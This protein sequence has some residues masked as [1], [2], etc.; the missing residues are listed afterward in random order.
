[1]NLFSLLKPEWHPAAPK[2]L[3]SSA[4][5]VFRA[6]E[7]DQARVL[8]DIFGI[9][10]VGEMVNHPAL[11]WVWRTYETFKAG[12]LSGPPPES[13]GFIRPDWRQ[14]SC[15]EWL[16]SPLN[17]LESISDEDGQRLGHV[18]N[19]ATVRNMASDTSFEAARVLHR[20]VTGEPVS[21]A[22]AIPKPLTNYFE[23]ASN[24]YM[25]RQR[26]GA[27]LPPI[28][29]P[30]PQAPLPPPPQLGAPLSG[31]LDSPPHD[32]AT[33]M[34]EVG[35]GA[36]MA[37]LGE[38]R[39]VHSPLP[40]EFKASPSPDGIRAWSNPPAGEQTYNEAFHTVPKTRRK[41]YSEHGTYIPQGG[42]SRGWYENQG[43]AKTEKSN[44]YRYQE[45]IDQT[46]YRDVDVEH[47]IHV[48]LRG[49]ER[50]EL[51][52]QVRFSLDEHEV[53]QPALCLD[54]SL[55]GVRIRLS[56][57]FRQAQPIYLTFIHRDDIQGIVTPLI[58]VQATVAWCR[59]VDPTFKNPRYDLGLE[60][61]EMTID[62]KEKVSKLMMDR[63]DE[64]LAEAPPPPEN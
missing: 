13:E 50:K 41:D 26:E 62:I 24:S 51:R 29:P 22:D 37:P 45:V 49:A 48:N 23:G 55:T 15:G 54:L 6:I 33:G 4:P 46:G 18:L 27:G 3:L 34:E 58:H 42:G 64:L 36:G 53:P 7:D 35:D 38:D 1:M 39:P 28:P 59:E 60:F 10:T 43:V 2:E 9:T 8:E 31:H 16:S 14:R 21:P 32:P 40:G 61:S 11:D 5:T 56:R 44:Q 63:I 57:R 30:P 19:W 25:N 47:K 12:I 20:M 52:M 17:S